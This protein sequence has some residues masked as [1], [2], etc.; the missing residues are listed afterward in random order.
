MGQ[1]FVP[2]AY[3][4][5]EL[6]HPKVKGRYLPSGLDVMAVM[7]SERAVTWLEQDISTQSPE[8]AEQFDQLTGWMEGLAQ[9]DWTETSYNAW[10]YTLQPLLEPAGRGIPCSCID[11]L[12]G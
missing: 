7:G 11:R 3:I 12:A 4:F 2:D 6:I 10:L 5:Q 9:Q 1:R 8:Y